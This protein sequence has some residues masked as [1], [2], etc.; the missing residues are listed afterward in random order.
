[1]QIRA[2][3]FRKGISLPTTWYQSPCDASSF[4][5]ARLNF[6]KKKMEKLNFQ[7]KI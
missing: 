7:A 5:H 3:K 4:L 6:K 1:M 2:G